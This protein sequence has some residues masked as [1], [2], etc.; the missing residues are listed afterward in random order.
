MLSD[1]PLVVAHRGSSDALAEHTLAA[2]DQAITDGADGLECDI[3][4]TRDGHLVCVHDRRLER[5]SDGRGPVSTRALAEL[6]ALD[7]GSWKHDLPTTA[8]DLIADRYWFAD[9]AI[10]DARRRV[11]TFERLLQLVVDASRPV[12]LYVETKHPT[13]YGGLVEQELVRALRRFGLDTVRDPDEARVAVM[14]FSTLAVRRVRELAPSVP[15]VQLFDRIP[16]LFRDGSLPFG[17]RMAGPGVHVLRNQPQYV[18]RVHAA[19]NQ[20]YVWTVNETAD[21]DLMLDLGVDVFATDRPAHV[22]SRMRRGVT[23]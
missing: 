7:F 8:D 21:V 13:R 19:G 12:R 6:D 2:Y 15:T 17:A 23:R 18:E 11:L 5:T 9:Q 3:R 10:L 1:G 20:V 16:V 4:L 14:S 22:V